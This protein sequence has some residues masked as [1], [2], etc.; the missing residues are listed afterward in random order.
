MKNKEVIDQNKPVF[1]DTR[2]RRRHYLSYSGA[3]MAIV[4]TVMLS[5]FIISVLINP[6]LP[7]IRLKPVA[8]LPQD[9]DITF[10]P[11]ERPLMTRA[12]TIAK[13]TGDKA[14]GEQKRRDERQ[15]EY[16]PSA[17]DHGLAIAR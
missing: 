15:N 4:A 7:Q 8:V 2:G 6:F 12:E 10:H 11:P 1:L 5:L 16:P 14:R 3:A 17:I 9:S 13:Q